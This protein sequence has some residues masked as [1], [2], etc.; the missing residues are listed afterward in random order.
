[1]FSSAAMPKN[2]SGT[3][4]EVRNAV[5]KEDLAKK[6]KKYLD[7]EENLSIVEKSSNASALSL[8]TLSLSSNVVGLI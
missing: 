2:L 4:K 3:L 5:E 7:E 6:H 1:M 8:C